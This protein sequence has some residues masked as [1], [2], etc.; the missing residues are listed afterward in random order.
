MQAI[1][2]LRTGIEILT[3]GQLIVDRRQAGDAEELLAMKR[4]E[5]SY[6]EIMAIANELHQGL[7]SACN[8]SSL[9]ERVDRDEVNQLCV[10]LVAKQGW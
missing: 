6:E 2:L 10:D 5:Y 8:E 3:T 4:G 9:P 1:R 7:D